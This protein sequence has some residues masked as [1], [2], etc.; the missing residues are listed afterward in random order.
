MAYPTQHEQ[1]WQNISDTMCHHKL[2]L[3][4]Q[5]DPPL[6]HILHVKDGNLI[7]NSAINCYSLIVT[8]DTKVC[9]NQTCV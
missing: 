1:N 4:I 7:F 6:E 3:I 5:C 8:S 9:Y 2:V